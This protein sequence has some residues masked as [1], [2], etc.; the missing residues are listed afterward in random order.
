MRFVNDVEFHVQSAVGN[1]LIANGIQEQ[2]LVRDLDSL[3]ATLT[4]SSL[5]TTRSRTHMGCFM[6]SPEA[7]VMRLLGVIEILVNEV[8]A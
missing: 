7:E 3:K 8:Q 6:R 4:L 1:I 5:P 2:I